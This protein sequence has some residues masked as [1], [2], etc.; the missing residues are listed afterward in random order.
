MCTG[1]RT[2]QVACKD[3]NRLDV[4]TLFREVKSYEVGSYPD[5]TFYHMTMSCNHCENPACVS[6]CPVGAMYVAEDGTV[7]LPPTT[8]STLHFAPFRLSRLSRPSNFFAGA[9]KSP[10]R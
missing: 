2:C 5:V 6:A 4:G 7:L 9:R 8:K 1:C 10:P 3:K